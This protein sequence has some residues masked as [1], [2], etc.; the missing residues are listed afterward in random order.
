MMNDNRQRQL[1]KRRG[2]FL[3]FLL[4]L[5]LL[6]PVSTQ[7]Q[8]SQNSNR[9]QEVEDFN[10]P[11]SSNLKTTYIELI[12][13]VFPDASLE[14]KSFQAGESI[15]V[16]SLDPKIKPHAFWR[17]KLIVKV[18]QMHFSSENKNHLALF[19][20]LRNEHAVRSLDNSFFVLAAFRLENEAELVD[21]VDAQFIFQHQNVNLWT[22][23]PL[24]PIRKGD[25]GIW[26][27]ALRENSSGNDAQDFRLV[28]LQNKKFE[29][30]LDELP[31]LKGNSACGFRSKQ[32]LGYFLKKDNGANYRDF[33]LTV[34]ENLRTNTLKCEVQPPADYDKTFDY[35][36]VWDDKQKRYKVELLKTE[37]AAV[38]P[39]KYS[40]DFSEPLE[41][42]G[43]MEVGKIY[44]AEIG[45]RG[46][47][48]WRL[49]IDPQAPDNTR[50]IVF[51]SAGGLRL[52]R[53][54]LLTEEQCN[55]SILFKVLKETREM[56]GGKFR[57]LYEGE[58]K[59]I[60]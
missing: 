43:E 38:A 55:A 37:S 23:T 40:A 8:M 6:V 52:P 33:S 26:L 13:K 3:P 30:L 48:E 54:K 31:T 53:A 49:K 19:L 34:T 1:L 59:A 44:R 56:I 45:C 16:G 41:F 47:P 36:A 10:R 11:V 32:S 7:A 29:V 27:V 14:T 46:N 18:F 28:A 51:W 58:I 60:K 2:I 9:V 42:A 25:D 22:E 12:R 15:P 17:G 24:V 20:M 5:P 4:L 21:A 57:T 39:T 50:A 35:Q